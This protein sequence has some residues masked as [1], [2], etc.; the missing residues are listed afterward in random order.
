MKEITKFIKE[1]LKI[2][3]NTKVNERPKYDYHPKTKRELQDLLKKLIEDRGNEGDFNNIDTSEI[4]DMSNLFDDLDK[5][6]GNISKWDVSNV[7]DMSFMFCGCRSFN[8]PLA[9]W[10]VS[11][12]TNM[13]YMFYRC[14]SFNQNIS[15]WDVYHVINMDCM[16]CWCKSF[17]QDISNWNVSNVKYNSNIL[18]KCPIEE[19]YKPKF[20]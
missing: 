16:F 7:T 3:S 1:G 14:E 2:T 19:K 15:K 11:K 12:V 8:Q 4:T 20:K 9:K 6:N 18:Y 5:F 13:K 17:N 10:D